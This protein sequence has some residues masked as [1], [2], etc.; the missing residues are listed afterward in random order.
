MFAQRQTQDCSALDRVWGWWW[1]CVLEIKTDL[2]LE[3]CET[4]GGIPLA[5]PTRHFECRKHNS[6]ACRPR[7]FTEIGRDYNHNSCPAVPKSKENP[8][9]SSFAGLQSGFF[10][11]GGCCCHVHAGLALLIHSSTRLTFRHNTLNS[12][13]GQDFC[14][15]GYLF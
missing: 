3:L 1:G 6:R 7:L 5:G 9:G 4:A 10:F 15:A 13:C 11:S 2:D 12:N 14:Q 8:K